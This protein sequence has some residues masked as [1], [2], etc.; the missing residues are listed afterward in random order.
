[1]SR[2]SAGFAPATR[3][4][5]RK[6]GPV[7][8][9]P[10]DSSSSSRA[11]WPTSTFAS[12]CG[13][14]L[15]VAIRRSWASA[16]IAAGR[17]PSADISRYS[18]SYSRPLERSVGVRYQVAP[19]NSSA[20]ACST[21]SRLRAGQ[22]M[23]ADEPL[24]RRRARLRPPRRPLHGADV[25][26]DAVASV[27]ER[28]A[29]PARAARSP[30]RTRSTP[31]RRRS[32]LPPSRAPRS[33]APRSSARASASR[34]GRSPRPPR[35]RRRAAR[36]SPIEPPISPTPSTAMRV[37]S[38]PPHA[39]SLSTAR[40]A[41]CR[42]PPRPA[43]PA[44]RSREVVRRHRLRPVA[45]RRLRI[46]VHLDDDPVRSGRGGRER[47]RQHEVAAPGGV[48]RVDHHGQVREL[49]EHRHGHDVEREARRRLERADPALAEDHVLVALLEDVLRRHQQLLERRR[50]AALQQHR[51][52][53]E[54]PI[55]ASSE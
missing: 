47:Q 20:R 44:R 9:R 35:R 8:G 33:I 51:H 43:A 6:L 24:V 29:R 39:V 15:I 1:M 54:R 25:A 46:V 32:P 36:A 10:C 22:R 21:P 49:L 5:S 26:D 55:S 17:A 34:P 31:R 4:A 16:A 18:R 52:D 53:P 3:V 45:D 27:R 11:A 48:A 41:R 28:L 2:H 37:R 42:R 38:G 23:A 30:A 12:T 50:Q 13:R 14:W 40:T 7:A 19:S